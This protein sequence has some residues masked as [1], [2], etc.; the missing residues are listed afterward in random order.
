MTQCGKLVT[1]VG[2]QFITLNVNSTYSCVYNTM[3][4]PQRVARFCLRQLRL[5]DFVIYSLFLSSVPETF[6][7]SQTV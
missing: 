3:A 1:V 2:R 5:V 6:Y 4:V 7:N